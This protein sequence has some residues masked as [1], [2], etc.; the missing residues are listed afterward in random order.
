MG[1]AHVF[2]YGQI[3]SPPPGSPANGAANFVS[4]KNVKDQLSTQKGFK[5]ITVHIHTP[6]GLVAEGF[7][8]YDFLRSLNLPITTIIEGSCYSIGTVIALAGDE[9]LMT[10][11]S[12]FLIHN[13]W[14]SIEGDSAEV[15]QYAIDLAL[16]ENKLADFYTKVTGIGP[17]LVRSLMSVETMMTPDQAKQHGFITGKTQDIKALV[18]L[19]PNTESNM[20]TITKQEFEDR[21]QKQESIM[22]KVLTT[23]AGIS[24]KFGH[25][26]IM[27]M[28]ANGSEVEFPDVAN[29]QDLKVG[30]K[31]TL[32]GSPVPD[33]DYIFPS[34]DNQTISFLNSEISAITPATD[35]SENETLKAENAVLASKVKELEGKNAEISAGLETAK[36]QVMNFKTEMV[37][38][39]SSLGS[40]FNYDGK[41]NPGGEQK[42]NTEGRQR[43]PIQNKK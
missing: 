12:Q 17:E 39:K 28:D 37:N 26:N 16:T 2:V 5:D 40:H 43:T 19:K 15:N 20:S 41:G 35:N 38:L 11:N 31:A 29:P 3:G 8:I 10:P 1:T 30:D 13:P 4:L 36:T 32:A 25:K 14:G 23:I 18:L 9:R 27:L 22:N 7:A 6:G 33:G 34:M 21:F 42:K 24:K